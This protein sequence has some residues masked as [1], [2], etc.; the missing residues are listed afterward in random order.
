MP[1]NEHR[2]PID[3]N[4]SVSTRPSGQQAIPTG[5]M[6]RE[7]P[8]ASILLARMD[9]LSIHFPNTPELGYA[10]AILEP[11]RAHRTSGESVGAVSGRFTQKRSGARHVHP[12]RAPGAHPATSQ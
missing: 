5:S 9:R 6:I 7:G 4:E 8:V 3:R 10:E 1:C 11:P 12:R 2:T